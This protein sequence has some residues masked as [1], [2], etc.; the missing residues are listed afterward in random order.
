[1]SNWTCNDVNVKMWVNGSQKEFTNEIPLQA[2][3]GVL[4]NCLKYGFF[5]SE[6][7]VIRLG[8]M[9]I[10]HGGHDSLRMQIANA[11]DMGELNWLNRLVYKLAI[12][13][14]NIKVEEN[15]SS[16]EIDAKRDTIKGIMNSSR[17]STF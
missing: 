7:E 15:I 6:Y 8:Q 4:S 9:K 2:E 5:I 3:Q 16:E 13:Q 17:I 1:M 14:S 11:L 10:E 12:Y